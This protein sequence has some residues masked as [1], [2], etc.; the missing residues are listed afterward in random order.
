MYGAEAGVE[1]APRERERE[2]ERELSYFVDGRA[3]LSALGEDR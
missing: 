1:V 3:I 2:R